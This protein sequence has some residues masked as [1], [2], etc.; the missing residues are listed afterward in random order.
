MENL[1]ITQLRKTLQDNS[2]SD[3]ERETARKELL[4]IL[5]ERDDTRTNA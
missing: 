1:I 2:K 3:I 4:K 5:G